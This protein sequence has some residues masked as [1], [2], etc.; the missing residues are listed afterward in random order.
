MVLDAQIPA[1]AEF[2]TVYVDHVKDTVQK[3]SWY[4]DAY[5]L[6][7]LIELYGDKKLSDI[8]P[9]DIDDYKTLRLIDAEPSTVNRELSALRQLFNLAKRWK[10]F[11]GE[12][13]VSVSKL[14]P[15]HNQKERILTYEVVST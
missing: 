13:P 8:T 1:L 2:I 10:R 3:R 5:G 12:N 15:E 7:R 9:K 11:F 6:R 14:L 4:R